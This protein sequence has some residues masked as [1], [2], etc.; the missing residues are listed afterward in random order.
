M[1]M[2]LSVPQRGH[3]IAR[4]TAWPFANR[5][6]HWPQRKSCTLIPCNQKP[7]L[8]PYALSMRPHRTGSGTNR[9]GNTALGAVGCALTQLGGALL[10][11]ACL[12]FPFATLC[13][14]QRTYLST[15]LSAAISQHLRHVASSPPRQ[16][17]CP[18]GQVE[19]VCTSVRLAIMIS[20]S[21]S[22]SFA[23]LRPQ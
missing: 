16:W 19:G 3:F 6:P 21:A 4:H 18:G 10:R 5:R 12:G 2:W 9:A 15:L 11:P 23:L 8:L 1:V 7:V 17:P 14:C 13:H 20:S 22:A